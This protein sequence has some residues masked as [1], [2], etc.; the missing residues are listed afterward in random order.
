MSTRFPGLPALRLFEASAR[1]LSFSEAAREAGLT[2]AAVSAQMR[3]LE[4]QLGA[5]LFHRTSRS[6]RL[7]REGVML[8]GAVAE[9]LLVLDEAAGRVATQTGARSLTITTTPSFAAKWLVPRLQRFRALCPDVDVR[10]DVSDHVVDISRGEADI[11]I[12][13]G[14]GAYPGAEAHQLF[15]EAVFPVCAPALLAG[16]PP[17]EK[18]RDLRRHTLIHLDWQAQGDAWPDWRMWLLAAGVDGV[19][20]TRGLHFTQ[21]SLALQAALDGHGVALGNTSLV[22]DDL[23]AGRLAKPFDVAVQVAPTFAYYLVIPRRGVDRPLNHAFRDWM[24][25]EIGRERQPGVATS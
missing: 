18:P 24:L 17:L 10:I 21:T 3:V 19:D 12:R 16:S 22:G 9:A 1:H 14:H 25:A 5:T 6:M 8:V 4:G 7:T 23:A 15:G 20:P 13:F 11:A 2:P